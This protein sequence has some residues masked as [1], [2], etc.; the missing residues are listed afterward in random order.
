MKTVTKIEPVITRVQKK[1]KPRVAAYCRVSTKNDEQL[2]SLEAQK[3]HYEEKITSNPE[4]E[5]AGVYYDEGI[6][7][8]KKETRPAL[9]RMIADCEA[10]K[11]DK[12][13]TKSLSRFARN[14]T[15]CIELVQKLLNLGISIL[16]EKENID[17]GTMESDFL[18]FVMSSLAEGESVSISNNEKWSIKHRFET[19]TYKVS[20]APFGYDV[21]DGEFL[22]NEEEAKWVRWIFAE[23]LSGKGST[24]IAKMLN[25]KRV[26]TKRGGQW[27]ATTIRGMLTNEKY[28]GSCL[29]Q[30]TYSDFRF[31]RHRNTGERAQYLVEE[32]HASII[33]QKVFDAVA[34][35]AEQRIREKNIKKDTTYRK[36][37]P[38]AS[39][40]ICGEC[41]ANFKRHV[42]S[43]GRLKYP[44]WICKGHLEK[45]CSMK[46]IKE[47]ELE[48]AFMTMI[49][50]LIFAQKEILKE[51]LDCIL[52]ESHK[53]NLIRIDEIDS[54]LEKNLEKRQT[55]RD[56]MSRGYVDPPLF[57]E[58][59]NELALEAEALTA[60]KNRLE[61]EVSWN[62]NNTEA[63]NALLKFTKGAK[64]SCDFDGNLVKQFLESATVHS[65]KEITFHLKCGL[66]LTER[67]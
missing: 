59:S 24:E 21:N 32:H 30:K 16:F 28:T 35:L 33:S 31:N 54:K 43:T 14:T 34:E 46:A 37:Y 50:K 19:G 63:L 60:E 17:T 8:T 25:E 51:L 44:V 2:L 41:E 55:L 56:L 6:S 61:K 58:Q 38:F 11:I 15:D 22:I 29:F 12:I 40:L 5:F 36:R 45:K 66:N 9:M 48:C 3:Q 4:W 42:N 62:M 18:L 49:N 27:R 1:A 65:R 53:K 20:Y 52:L 67:F 57:T 23:A 10:G 47:S 26:P 7:G 64:M 39:K 13:L